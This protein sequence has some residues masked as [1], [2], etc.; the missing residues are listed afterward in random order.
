MTLTKIQE[1][2]WAIGMPK[3]GLPLSLIHT[4][5]LAQIEKLL[6]EYKEEICIQIILT[7]FSKELE[8]SAMLL[9]SMYLLNNESDYLRF[10][11]DWYAKGRHKKEDCYKRYRLNPN[12]KDMLANFQAQNEWVRRNTISSTPTVLTNG[13]LLPEEYELKDMSYLIN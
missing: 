9:T 5:L 2:Y 6:K 1:Y 7:S 10:L 11:S 3:S 8:P 12:D 13:Y 4:V